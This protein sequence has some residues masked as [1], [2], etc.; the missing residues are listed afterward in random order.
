MDLRTR[1]GCLLCPKLRTMS[2]CPHVPQCAKQLENVFMWDHRNQLRLVSLGLRSIP[3]VQEGSG[4]FVLPNTRASP[5]AS[6]P[7]SPAFTLVSRL[8][9]SSGVQLPGR[10][11]VCPQSRLHHGSS[12]EL[13]GWS[14]ST[15]STAGSGSGRRP[16]GQWGAGEECQT[17]VSAPRGGKLSPGGTCFGP[18]QGQAPA[19]RNRDCIH[20]LLIRTA[21]THT[22][23]LSRENSPP[24]FGTL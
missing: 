7:A 21:Y 16:A 12:G 6:G 11:A 3:A 4:S 19:S 5:A 24:A 8:P 14:F 22:L 2:I 18:N 20:T 9:P 15:L 17:L 1:S 23:S 10:S 13:S